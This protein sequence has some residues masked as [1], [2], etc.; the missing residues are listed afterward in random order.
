LLIFVGPFLAG[1]AARYVGMFQIEMALFDFATVALVLAFATLLW[2]KSLARQVAAVGGYL[3]AAGVLNPVLFWRFD[4]VPAALAFGALYLAAT[5]RELLGA[6]LL[7]L[8]GSVKLWPLALAPLWLGASWQRQGWRRATAEAI[9]MGAGVVLPLTLF[10]VR[11]RTG[12]FGFLQF[13]SERSLQL[14][15]SWAN[16]ALLADAI[17]LAHSRITYNHGAFNVEGTLAVVLKGIGRLAL[18][19]LV[20]IPQAF[21][22]RGRQMGAGGLPARAGLDAATASVL[23][24]LL[25][26]S[27][28]SPQFMLWVIPLLVL[29]G[30]PGIAAAIAIAGFTTAIYPVLYD[31]LVL[32]QSPGY[33]IA[34]ACLTMRNLL[35]AAAYALFVRRLV[36]RTSPGTV[37][38]GKPDILTAAA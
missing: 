36:L 18:L 25:G 17:G 4:L 20:F 15:S 27:V 8:G 12:I 37:R 16:L 23:G 14:E 34:V 2:P 9:A 31:P 5:R 7:G 26:A 29:A 22:L 30:M 3:V 33:G 10:I 24:L 1:G 21:A 6:V 13:H 35:L 11:A 32:H 19:A 38:G 28:L